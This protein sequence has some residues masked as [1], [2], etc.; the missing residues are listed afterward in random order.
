MFDRVG[1]SHDR[2]LGPHRVP[3]I[4]CGNCGQS[5]HIDVAA[6]EFQ[7][8]C[9]E[10]SAFLRRPTSAEERAFARFMDWHMRHREAGR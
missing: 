6:G 9:D 4:E 7:G 1:N 3:R 8:E 10:C 5:H 2:I